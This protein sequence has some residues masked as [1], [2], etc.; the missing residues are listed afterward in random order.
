M[1]PWEHLDTTKVADGAE[2]RLLRRGDEFVIRIGRNDL[3]NSRRSGSEKA[4]AT[5]SCARI[6]GR[7]APAV[8][9]GGLGM[10]FTLRAALSELPADARVVVA[11]LVPAVV[12]WAKGPMAEIFAGCLDDPRVR[13]HEGDVLALIEAGRAAYDAILLDVDNG[14]DGLTSAANDRLYG[15]RGL[16]ASATALRPGGVLAV[17]SAA[18]DDAFAARLRR[19]GF[20]VEEVRVPAHGKRGV[21]HLIWIA[22]KTG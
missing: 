16:G 2:L 17:W 22:T 12:R 19:T 7:K 4:L 1:I 13:V 15:A 10:G 6:A 11:E 21:R 14:P 18:P 8:L 5:L 3:M 20:A 9:I